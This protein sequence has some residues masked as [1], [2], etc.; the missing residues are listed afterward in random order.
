[1]F[2]T[3]F[4]TYSA[5]DVFGQKNFPNIKDKY[6]KFQNLL[7]IRLISNWTSFRTIQVV[8]IINFSNQPLTLCSSD[9]EITRKITP[10]IVLHSVQLLLSIVIISFKNIPCTV[11]TFTFFLCYVHFHNLLFMKDRIYVPLHYDTYTVY[12]WQLISF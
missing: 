1:M 2:H 4:N 3:V 9:F 11:H 6:S 7:E 10:W 12:Q 8:I 5:T